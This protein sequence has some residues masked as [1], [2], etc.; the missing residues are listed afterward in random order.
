MI[1]N[2]K[3]FIGR[4]RGRGGGIHRKCKSAGVTIT[5]EMS[6]VVADAHP[7]QQTLMIGLHTHITM[8]IKNESDDKRESFSS[9]HSS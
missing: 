6:K 4:W 5:R 1:V 9:M 3:L 8:V 2:T 7:V